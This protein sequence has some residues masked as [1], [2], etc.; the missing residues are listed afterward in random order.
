MIKTIVILS[1]GVDSTT[2]LYLAI[3]SANVVKALGFNYGQKHSKELQCAKK[4]CKKIGI[5]YRIADISD[6]K[7]LLSSSLTSKRRIPKGHYAEENMISTVVPNRNAIMLSIAY[8]YA[9]SEK[10]DLLF[11]GAHTGDHFIYPDCRPRF[12]EELDKALMIGNEGFGDVHIVAPFIK[13][14]KAEIVA[15][16]LKYKVPYET[17]WSC[18]EGNER[19]CLKCGTCVERTEAFLLNNVKDPLLTDREWEKAVKYYN[20]CNHILHKNKAQK[21]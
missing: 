7:K 16:G 21:K 19:P 1:G 3:A 18:Y 12:V 8:G 15:Y 9:V 5:D 11:F 20:D 4:L 10:A 2:V 17:T 14:S 13:S 6:V